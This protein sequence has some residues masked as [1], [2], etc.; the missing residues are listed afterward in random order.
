MKQN[1]GKWYS[2]QIQQLNAAIQSKSHFITRLSWLRLVSFLLSLVS[3]GFFAGNQNL[4]LLITSILLFILFIY[5][6]IRHIRNG[7]Q[8]MR[9][10][11]KS[12]VLQH[13][14][15]INEQH[16]AIYSDGIHFRSRLM[17]ADDM[18]LFG[19][20]SLFQQLN[21]CSTPVGEELLA[22]GLINTM[23]EPFRIKM[24][25]D[26]VKE[27]SAFPEFRI[28][29][30]TKLQQAASD[31]FPDV[32]GMRNTILLR[33]FQ[34]KK[35]KLIAYTLPVLVWLSL[36][37]GF[38][39]MGY[40]AFSILAVLALMV[41]FSQARKLMILGSELDGLRKKFSAW[42]SVLQQLTQLDLKSELLVEM[43]HEAQE[44]ARR[45]EELAKISEQFDRRSNL[46]LFVLSNMFLSYDLHLA[47]RYEKW[48][49]NYYAQIPHWIST[50][51]RFELLLS[52]SAFAFNHPDYCWPELSEQKEL[53]AEAIGH[54]L[55]PE[56]E[57]VKNSLHLKVDPRI[58]LI[59]GSNMSGK[60]TWLRTLGVNVLLAQLGAPVMAGSFVWK[61]MQLLSSLRQSD[62]LAEHTS[63][64]MNELKQ[65][66]SI[67]ELAQNEFSLILLDEILRGTN[68]D[69]KYTGSY[70]LLKRLANVDSLTV[71]A[72]HDLKL[73]DLE[74]ELE[75]K[76]VNYCFESK[77]VDGKLTF[78]YTIKKGVAVNR[79]ATWLMKDMG[80]I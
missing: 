3:F 41:V 75:G 32:N 5:F 66:K 9:M 45:F 6:T 15:G 46:L 28:D 74:R 60:S 70:E 40:T 36:A 1:P 27:L 29:I 13:E 59:T 22:H 4:V 64:F 34:E 58:V 68:S 10:R 17:F 76:L 57:C 48:R 62:S 43:Q 50:L 24:M 56:N 16:E 12:R 47:L 73:S 39:G 51:G 49:E 18:D 37:A 38:V 54:P 7:R 77:I 53:H 30:Q 14:L 35:F 79:N 80:I 55:L 44:A 33:L 52:L 42:A 69:D 63:L 72:S 20:Y 25:Q 8:L 67:L 65:L 11:S 26:A 61:P 2:S 19:N 23:R 78:D 31:K 21:R 71:I